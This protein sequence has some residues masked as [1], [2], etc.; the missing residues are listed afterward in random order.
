MARRRSFGTI[1]QLPSGR[2]QARSPGPDGRLRTAPDTFESRAD[3]GRFL[4]AIETDMQRGLWNDPKTGDTTLRVY[5]DAWLA[6]RRV[7]GRPLAPGGCSVDARSIVDGEPRGSPTVTVSVRRRTIR[8]AA[9][10][11][12]WFAF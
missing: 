4:S 7:R 3:A 2:Y 5:A 9:W 10:S 12:F 6:E 8:S 11:R 1:R